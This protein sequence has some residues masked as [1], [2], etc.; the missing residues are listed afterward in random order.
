MAE[1]D[2]AEGEAVA[3]AAGDIHHGVGQAAGVA[4]QRQ[5]AVAQA[6]ELGEA[7][8]FGAAR[9]QE[10]IGAG[11]DAVGER[12]VVAVPHVDPAGMPSLQLAEAVLQLHVARAEHDE[13]HASREDVRLHRFGDQVDALLLDQTADHRHQASAFVRH[14]AEFV[15]QAFTTGLLAGQL[16]ELE[17][18]RQVFVVGRIPRVAV[19]AV[20]DTAELV[21][22]TARHRFQAE[23]VLRELDLLRIG[24][25]D[26]GHAV[27]EHHAGFQQVEATVV[28]QVQRI[29]QRP[30]ETGQLHVEV[31]DGALV[32]DVVDGEHR[33]RGRQRLV[34]ATLQQRRDQAGL[35]VVRMHH[36]WRPPEVAG[37]RQRALAEDRE[38]PGVVVVVVARTRS[39]D[40][41]AIE[42]FV[43]RQQMHRHA[44]DLDRTDTQAVIDATGLDG[45]GVFAPGQS[46]L[47][48]GGDGL[49]VAG[50][51][52]AHVV[53]HGF[54]RLRQGTDDIRQSSGLHQGH[55]LAGGV[56]DAQSMMGHTERI[57]R[58]AQSRRSGVVT[59]WITQRQGSELQS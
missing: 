23:G 56:E 21:A 47:R 33:A 18:G 9:H 55:G 20:D 2:R 48:G 54:Q 13:L 10:E 46:E 36:V 11:D 5:R 31:P 45:H 49:A 41:V 7:A 16:L 24:A 3:V 58:P 8:R 38:A 26:G 19:D 25:A 35:P 22:V 39:V 34:E 43:A 1:V 37:Q 17:A 4:H 40:A 6:V 52:H 14:Q 29:E 42:Q 27:G 15:A 28:L 44:T 50:D 59:P 57:P 51:D 12:V 30:V 32:G 53:A